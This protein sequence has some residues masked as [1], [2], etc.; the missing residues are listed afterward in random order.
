MSVPEDID[1]LERM[2]EQLRKKYELYFSGQERK[3]PAQD[4]VQV[5]RMARQLHNAFI[6]NSG[7][8]YRLK[9]V[10]TTLTSYQTYWDRVLRQM[11]EGTYKR[12][13]DKRKIIQKD[14]AIAREAERKGEG[15]ISMDEYLDGDLDDEIGKAALD[16]IHAHHPPHHT[17]AHARAAEKPAPAK[18]A[19]S[20]VEGPEAPPPPPKPAAAQ[21]PRP[22]AK[23][24][25][26]APKPAA[27]DGGMNPSK[28]AELYNA[29]ITAR[30]TLGEQNVNVSLDGFK[31]QLEKQI[32]ALRQKYKTDAIDF[33][34]SIKGGKASIKAVVGSTDDDG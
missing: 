24:A 8:M 33:R 26:A 23:P 34:I 4:R 19:P 2:I 6:T 27:P 14:M 25:A 18:P 31:K 16:A 5:E 3:E 32:P 13:I 22:A 29:Y 11:E 20:R 1:R 15:Y 9:S 12:E 30:R 7:I 21:A 10:S 28:V 17:A